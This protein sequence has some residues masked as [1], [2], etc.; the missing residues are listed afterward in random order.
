MKESTRTR[1]GRILTGTAHGLI[2]AVEGLAPLTVMEQAIREVDNAIDDVR[3]DLGSTIADK[4]QI[5]KAVTQLNAEHLELEE[6]IGIALSQGK[7]PLAKAGLSRQVDIEDQLPTLEN[8]IKTIKEQED[9]LNTAITSLIAKRNHMEQELSELKLKEA[10]QAGF[11]ASGDEFGE[12]SSIYAAERAI[13]AFDRVLKEE[14]SV[15][16]LGASTQDQKDLLELAKI[17]KEAKIQAKLN[18]LKEQNAQWFLSY[19][20]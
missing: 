13:S 10:Q 11:D 8:Q 17:S 19:L 3:A 5:T 15:G 1:I 6:Q 4:H 2:K 12:T 7:E 20:I 16:S 9:E 18:A 14:N